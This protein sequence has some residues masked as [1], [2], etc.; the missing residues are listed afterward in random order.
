MMH[1]QCIYLFAFCLDQDIYDREINNLQ[2]GLKTKVNKLYEAEK[3]P[4][5]K[6]YNLVALS[7]EDKESI[8]Q[9]I[10]D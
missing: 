2:K 8:S 3:K 4:E 7:K 1:L 10:G 5:L 9:L 6:G